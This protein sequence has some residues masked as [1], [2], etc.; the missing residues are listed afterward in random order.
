ML[1]SKTAFVKWNSKHKNYYISKGYPFTKM[2]DEFEVKIED[3]TKGSH[4][5]V[6][7]KCDCD[8]CENPYLKPI[9][10]KR[11]LQYLKED[12]KY[13]CNKCAMILY[14]YKNRKKVILNNSISFEQWCIDNNYKDVL[15]RWDYELN[16]NIKPSDITYSANKKFYFKCPRELH[17]SELKSINLFT[18]DREGVM[19]CKTCNSFAQWGIDNIGEDFLEKYWDYKKNKLNPW[20]ISK[21]NSSHQVFIKCQEKDYHG[22]YEILPNTFV[23]L[24]IRCS[25]CGTTS[26]KVHTLDSLGTLY[27]EVLKIWSNKNNKSPYEYAPISN[28]WV[29]WKCP[30]GKHEDYY[31]KI[32]SSNKC[33]FRCP[34]CQYSKG[35]KAINDYFINKDFIKIKQDEYNKLLE[36][37]K[38]NNT[39][40]IPQK[41]FDGLIGIKG[42][43]LSYDFYLPKLNFLI[44]YQGEQH[45]HPVDFKR[46]GKKHAQK[47]FIIQKEHDRRKREYAKNNSIRLL[48]IWYYDFDNIEEI[49][50]EI[51]CKKY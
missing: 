2:R 12:D 40:Y 44:E 20:E 30:E 21:C 41:E 36:I 11:Y 34:E 38:I 26:K 28:Q 33:M 32:S 15:E 14:G 19:N 22:S 8:D 31:R 24:N 48:E 45:E 18:S 42:G 37:D 29:W 6:N 4:A 49:L 35:E 25:Y 17:K 46:K 13:Y 43:L 10:W 47:Q 1:I 5:L 27:P 39:Y 7:V 51:L 16:N 3:L 23:S 50:E 9:P